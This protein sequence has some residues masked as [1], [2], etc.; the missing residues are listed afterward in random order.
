MGEKIMVPAGGL[1]SAAKALLVPENIRAGVHIKGGGVDVVGGL[2]PTGSMSA[3]YAPGS[4]SLPIT[5]T[6]L[7]RYKVHCDIGNSGAVKASTITLKIQ[8]FNDGAWVVVH[9]E[10]KSRAPKSS[11]SLGYEGDASAGTESLKATVTSTDTESGA[12]A[13]IKF[14][15]NKE[16]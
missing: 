7:T 4:V 11:I 5:T 13:I 6:E 16:D 8:E 2:L 12:I 3:G 1:P 10:S 15:W 9:T 14:G